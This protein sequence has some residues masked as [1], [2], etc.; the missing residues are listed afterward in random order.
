MTLDTMERWVS[1]GTPFSDQP[2]DHKTDAASIQCNDSVYYG[3]DACHTASY[4]QRKV[5]SQLA[6]SSSSTGLVVK[7]Q[8]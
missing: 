4:H 2:F 5:T 8:D 6:V 7:G 3:A 1:P